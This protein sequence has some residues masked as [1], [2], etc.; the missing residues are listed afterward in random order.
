MAAT[1]IDTAELRKFQRSFAHDDWPEPS[2][3][4][5]G[6]GK[7]VLTDDHLRIEQAGN[8]ASRAS[9]K[10]QESSPFDIS[11][12]FHAALHCNHK[13]CGDW[14]TAT[15]DFFVDQEYDAKGDWEWKDHLRVRT[16]YPPIDILTIPDNTPKLVA[17][18]LRRAAGVTWLDPN[19]AVTALRTALERLMD[20]QMV[21]KM[22][23]LHNRIEHYRTT[24]NEKFGTLLLAVKYVGNGGA[25]ITDPA[26]A[27]TTSK[28]VIDMAEFIGI[29]I[30]G[31]YDPDDHSDAL[32]RA[33]RINTA[34]KLVD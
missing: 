16:M 7:L 21:K 9:I 32:S 14:V 8:S 29:V 25:H 24:D 28:D 10:A 23:N 11:G 2:C 17:A 3:P 30:K 5:C 34:G 12:A 22:S 6:K 26:V 19:S 33:E 15:G 4:I 31:L 27:P 13:D 18:E 1:T 20:D